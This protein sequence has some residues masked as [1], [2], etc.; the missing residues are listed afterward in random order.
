MAAAVAAI[1]RHLA[2]VGKAYMMD[3][4]LMPKFIITNV[5]IIPPLASVSMHH[6]D[7][8]VCRERVLHWC[9]QP[10]HSA[11]THSVCC[12]TWCCLLR[13]TMCTCMPYTATFE[14]F[15]TMKRIGQGVLQPVELANQQLMAFPP[16]EVRT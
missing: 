2:L 13:S 1:Q 10:E 4:S 15:V 11:A 7:R 12:S 9:A 6:A 8:N 5:I 14:G 3:A 16:R